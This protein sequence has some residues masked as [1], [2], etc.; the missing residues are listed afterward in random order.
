MQRA[1]PLARAEKMQAYRGMFV[2][3][4]SG[5]PRLGPQDLDAQLFANLAFDGSIQ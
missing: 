1:L 4:G 2:D 3:V 5:E